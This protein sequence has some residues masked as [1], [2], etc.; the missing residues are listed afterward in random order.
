MTPAEV[1]GCCRQNAETARRRA[2]NASGALALVYLDAE[3]IEWDCAAGV[4]EEREK[5]VTALAGMLEQLDEGNK[6]LS[7]ENERLR[8]A[9]R[10]AGHYLHGYVGNGS[11]ARRIGVR[12]LAA[13]DDPSITDAEMA[14]LWEMQKEVLIRPDAPDDDEV[15]P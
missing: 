1:A 15:Q 14:A 2:A 8:E 9:I 3:A 10:D 5:D 4:I 11:L 7:A 13:L 6:Y 12:L